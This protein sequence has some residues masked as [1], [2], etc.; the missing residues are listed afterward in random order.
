VSVTVAA[1]SRVLPLEGLRVV[2]LTMNVSGPYATMILG[3]L[4]ASV[5]KIERPHHGDDTRRWQP[6][7]GDGSAYFYAVN[8]NKESL[9]VDLTDDAGRRQVL[10]LLAGADAFVTNL[11][12]P[13]LRTLGLDFESLH[14]SFPAL[15]YADLSGYGNDGPESDRAG[16]DMVLQARSGVMSVTGEEGR[17]PVRVGVS[18]LD[19]GSGLWLALGLLAALRVRDS[20]GEGCRVSTSLLEVG[21]AFMAYDVAAF[22]LTGDEP[23]PRGTGHP[24]FAPYGVFLAI[25]VGGDGVFRRL[26]AALERTDWLDDPR[27]AT[28]IARVANRDALRLAIEERL[29]TRPASDW[30][31]V[32]RDAE[33]PAD[34]LATTSRILTDP[35]LHALGCWV[36]VP[37]SDQHGDVGVLRQP[38]LPIRFGEARPPVRL[39][40]PPLGGVHRVDDDGAP[41][42]G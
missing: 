29:G 20:T 42:Q 34:G 35:Q 38:G 6:R 27:F 3:D 15:I 14:R 12:P 4:G 24:S 36:D 28:N 26:A 40:P 31:R 25:G 5:T 1:G 13:K 37:L 32:L 23:G 10:D 2:D 19:M 39:G 30:A 22:Q 11:R 16:Y 21:A 33:V 18:I 8:R 41:P 17:P 7:H 9:V